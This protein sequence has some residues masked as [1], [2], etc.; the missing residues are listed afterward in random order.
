MA[1]TTFS[2]YLNLFFIQGELICVAVYA[3]KALK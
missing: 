3:N 2:K 1:G